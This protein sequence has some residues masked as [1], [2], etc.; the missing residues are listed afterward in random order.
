VTAGKDEVTGIG[1]GIGIGPEAL[2]AL[3]PFH[4]VWD[5]GFRVLQAG[6][7]IG[8][9]VPELRDGCLLT[10]RFAIHRPR[11]VQNV[12]DL[13]RVARDGR[14]GGR[15]A[16]LKALADERLALRGQLV[17]LPDE[18]ILFFGSPVAVDLAALTA[19]GLTLQDF[20]VH[21]GVADFL[22]VKRSLT[23]A[24]TEADQMA[25]ELARF[26][27]ELEE[28]VGERT[29][30]LLESNEELAQQRQE[31]EH[32]H[33]RLQAEIAER[34]RVEEDLRLA[35]KLEA[36]G[37]LAAGIAHEIN[38]PV[39]FVGNNVSFLGD[40]LGR[41]DDVAARFAELAE[42]VERAELEAGSDLDPRYLAELARLAELATAARTAA[43]AADLSYLV[44]EG[45]RAVA[46]SLDG[47]ARVSD[48]VR[49]MREFAHP[50][51]AELVPADLN[52]CVETTLAVSRNEYRDVAD[53]VTDLDPDLP[54][55]PCLPGEINQ[56]L[57]NLFVNA[58]HAIGERPDQARGTI[59]VRTGMVDAEVQIRVQDDGPGIPVEV[60][61]KIFDPFFTTK[62]VGRGIGQGL[63]TSRSIV[64]QRHHGRLTFSSMP[65]WT[66]FVV[67]LPLVP[68][69]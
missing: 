8:R 18:R 33:A 64:T 59:R 15:L 55:V 19:L 17:A 12:D 34:Q 57:L 68:P 3:A 20:A 61:G 25:G 31:L 51:R 52:R 60:Q 36:V 1:T 39:Q 4:L 10:D 6:E 66:E 30:L 44:D 5:R 43:E 13:V 14:P 35:H 69:A 42:A 53:V 47:T 2:A 65:G 27:G 67:A 49:A 37:Q 41:I 38:T 29:S 48:I 11:G 32:A 58:A 26:N 62:E 28:R 7:V 46:E 54:P 24:L 21:D 23:I 50:D 16:L 45:R 40:A 9:L 22:M 56:V 63:S